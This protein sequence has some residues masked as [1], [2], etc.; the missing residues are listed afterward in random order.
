MPGTRLLKNAG[1]YQGTHNRYDAVTLQIVTTTSTGEQLVHNSLTDTDAAAIRD[2]LL[3]THPLPQPTPTPTPPAPQPPAPVTSSKPS[4]GLVAA[5]DWLAALNAGIAAIR[6]RLVRLDSARM[7]LTSSLTSPTIAAVKAARA[8]PVLLWSD[9]TPASTP[10]MIRACADKF[11]L[12]YV[13]VGNEDFYDYAGKSTSSSQARSTA[14]AYALQIKAIHSAL[15]GTGCQ[16]LAQ[17]DWPSWGGVE[18]DAIKAAV[19]N[20]PDYVDGIT[21]HPYVDDVARIQTML[22]RWVALGGRRDKPVWA[23]EWGIATDDGRSLTPKEPK[24]GTIYGRPNNL[25][26]EQAAVLVRPTYERIKAACNLAAFFAYQDRDQR[27][28]GA[29][30]DPEHYFGVNQLTAGKPGPP[31]PFYADAIKALG[32]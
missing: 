4:L 5:P 12:R 23:T 21:I 13:E 25:T 30:V 26:Y 2:G 3:K 31:K 1:L 8:D 16:V 7:S 18:V 29:S 19:P 22:L 9:W 14:T 32:A 17:A 15:A 27:A 24:A 28:S 11:R 10:S 6:P 20:F